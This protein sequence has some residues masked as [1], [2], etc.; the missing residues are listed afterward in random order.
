MPKVV[1]TDYT[2]PSLDVVEVSGSRLTDQLAQRAIERISPN[3]MSLYGS[4]ETG[5]VNIRRI[6][7]RS[8]KDESGASLPFVHTARQLLVGLPAAAQGQLW[9]G[10]TFFSSANHPDFKS[11][12]TMAADFVAASG[13]TIQTRVNVGGSLP[14]TA[15]GEDW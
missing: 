8:V 7:V 14:I 1:I 6:H 13:G 11:L 12:E 10:Y 5:V 3:L 4:T 2:F 9:K 15:T